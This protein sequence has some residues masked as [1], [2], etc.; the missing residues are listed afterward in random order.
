MTAL[1]SSIIETPDSAPVLGTDTRNEVSEDPTEVVT[2]GYHS[3]GHSQGQETAAMDCVDLAMPNREALV[4]SLC[5]LQRTASHSLHAADGAV[6]MQ[7]LLN[8]YV[9]TAT[10]CTSHTSRCR[11]FCDLCV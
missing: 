7:W 6:D 8:Q 1:P 3:T 4:R 11:F 9:R 2:N 10:A 5:G